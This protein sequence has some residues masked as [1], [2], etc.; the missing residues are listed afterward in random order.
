[1]QPSLKNLLRLFP[2]NYWSIENVPRRAVA[3]EG[4]IYTSTDFPAEQSIFLHN[5]NSYQHTWPMKIFFFCLKSA[6]AG[7][8]TPLADVRKVLQRID[9][10]IAISSHKNR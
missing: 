4:N 10:K 5:E 3:S 8:E 2:G 1:M 6:T 7:G 9:P